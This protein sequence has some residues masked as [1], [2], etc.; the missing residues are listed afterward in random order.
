MLNIEVIFGILKDTAII[1]SGATLMIQFYQTKEWHHT[2]QRSHACICQKSI[3]K[4]SLLCLKS[5]PK[6]Y[7]YFSSSEN[8]QYTK[9][10]I[11]SSK[12]QNVWAFMHEVC[13]RARGRLCARCLNFCI[14]RYSCCENTRFFPP[15]Y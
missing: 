7:C 11:H 3:I 6:S 13:I 1:T 4:L 8:Q 10:K 5:S 2:R 9:S 12:T 15:P 14:T